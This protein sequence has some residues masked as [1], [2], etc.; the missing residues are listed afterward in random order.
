MIPESID[1]CMITAREY[2]ISSFISFRIRGE[3]SSA[4]KQITCTCT[5]LGL[6]VLDVSTSRADTQTVDQWVGRW[7]ATRAPTDCGRTSAALIECA[8]VEAG[9]PPKY[10]SPR[11]L[12][13]L[14][15]DCRHNDHAHHSVTI[16]SV[17]SQKLNASE[18][19]KQS[20]IFMRLSSLA[21]LKAR[22]L[23]RRNWNEL[24]WLGPSFWRTDQRANSSDGVLCFTEEMNTPAR[25]LS[26]VQHFAASPPLV[27]GTE[28]KEVHCSLHA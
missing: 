6:P 7:S 24:T 1:D 20:T 27:H 19:Q 18:L 12:D 22:I 25:T 21:Y 2:H 9:S 10:D 13:D 11:A 15:S 3:R 14:C 23:E 5:I 8:A 16:C 4:P 26:Y 28:V 17:Q